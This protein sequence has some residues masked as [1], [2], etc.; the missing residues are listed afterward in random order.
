MEQKYLCPHCGVVMESDADWEAHQQS[1]QHK[2]LMQRYWEQ[3]GRE[4]DGSDILE[5]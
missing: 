3:E 1:P 2:E 5:L 4:E